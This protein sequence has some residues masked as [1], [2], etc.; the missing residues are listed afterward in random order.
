MSG[1][2][3]LL[4]QPPSGWQGKVLGTPLPASGS[5]RSRVHRTRV[6]CGGLG[7]SLSRQTSLSMPCPGGEEGGGQL[8]QRQRWAGRVGGGEGGYVIRS[9]VERGNM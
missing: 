1:Q 3:P 5:R 2:S 8:G 4:G 6:H 7:G 9:P